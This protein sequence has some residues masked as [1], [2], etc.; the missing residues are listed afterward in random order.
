MSQKVG[1]L[2]FWLKTLGTCDPYFPQNFK[3]LRPLTAI[4][5]TV[6]FRTEC[7]QNSKTFELDCFGVMSFF[8]S[9]AVVQ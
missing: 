5:H 4:D 7:S 3:Y 9:S 8:A 1:L 2:Q 6:I